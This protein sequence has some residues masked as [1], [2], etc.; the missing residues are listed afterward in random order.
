LEFEVGERQGV[1][2]LFDMNR[3][4]EDFVSA[5]L[6]RELER[7]GGRTECQ[8]V[9]ALDQRGDIDI[10]PD[11]VWWSEGACRAVIDIKYKATSVDEVP[12][13]DMYQVMAY[14]LGF[15]VRP[16]FLVYAAG[17]ERPGHHKVLHSDIEIVI[18]ALDVSG[19][20]NTILESVRAVADH[21]ARRTSPNLSSGRGASERLALTTAA[22]R[23]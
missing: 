5:T 23:G 10:K 13:A 14:C 4:F 9:H 12:N 19:Q 18:T 16:G 17:N 8:A 22:A 11:L 2:F 1:A 3:V 21:I 15:D 20:P 7:I 6:R